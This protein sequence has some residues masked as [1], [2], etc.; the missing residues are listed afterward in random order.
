MRM[1]V[2]PVQGFRCEISTREHRRRLF[3]AMRGG[4]SDAG[5]AYHSTHKRV[6]SARLS[7]V[8]TQTPW[9]GCL[10]YIDPHQDRASGTMFVNPRRPPT[11]RMGGMGGMGGI[12]F[13]GCDSPVLVRPTAVEST[14]VDEG[15]IA[16]RSQF[17][18]ACP[19]LTLESSARMHNRYTTARCADWP[20]I[21][22]RSAEESCPSRVVSIARE[23]GQGRN[24]G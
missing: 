2:P 14:S 23:N 8:I 19:H 12:V 18:R 5:E 16:T 6:P 10:H 7:P 11:D 3:S 22:S 15:G 20:R 21:S 24:R 13:H 1:R 4:D 17:A 9:P